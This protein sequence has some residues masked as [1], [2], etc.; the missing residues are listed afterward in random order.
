MRILFISAFYPPYVV[1]GWEQLVQDINTRLQA[2]GHNTEVLTSIHGVKEP[3]SEKG[4][5]RLLTLESD[6]YHYQPRQFLSHKKRLENNLART[7]EISNTFNP[8]VIFI[9]VMWNL[10]RGIAWLAEQLCPGRVVYYIAN[11]WPH[12]S[13][14]HSAYWLEPARN[15]LLKIAKQVVAPIP[16]KMIERENERFSLA[17]EHVLCVSQAVKN[18]LARNTSIHPDRMQVVYNGVE[19]DLFVP[20]P[21]RSNGH[22]QP[23]KGLSL[24]YAGS[25]V[26]HKGVHTAVE[27]MAILAQKSQLDG[28]TLSLVGS[29]HPDYE[30][31]LKKLIAK[32]H[33][34]N[35]IYFRGRVPRDE[36]PAMLQA[37]DVLIFPSIWEE[38]LARMT[39]EAMA[40]G[41][42]VI[43]TLTGGT[44]ELL[45]EG[46]TGLTFEPKNARMLAQRINQLRQDPELRARLAKN[47][48]DKVMRQFD[49][50]RMIDEIET[51]LTSVVQ[52]TVGETVY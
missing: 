28:I 34:E 46:E 24:V 37:H 7:K 6:L 33:L 45:I 21:A 49:I 31:S 19:T 38:P 15:P 43:G 36:M 25:L 52:A 1:G 51:Y 11:D 41:L 8:D 5:H 50:R 26:P 22:H 35:H 39:Q 47:G 12:A 10:S 29:G 32:A 48:R 27:A 9:H 30:A 3:I 2:R 18:D 20:S 40:A 4:V 23:E 17:F 13:D 14:P 16:L 42:V 44:G